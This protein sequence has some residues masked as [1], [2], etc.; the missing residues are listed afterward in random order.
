MLTEPAAALGVSWLRSLPAGAQVLER[1]VDAF[2]V[3]ALEPDHLAAR[4]PGRRG[5]RLVD[6][7]LVPVADRPLLRVGARFWLVSERVLLPGCGRPE[8]VSAI[9]FQR[10]GRSAESLFLPNPSSP[11]GAS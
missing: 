3:A 6:L 9:R 8:H 5:R 7:A 4:V 2:V 10:P 11:K 1:R